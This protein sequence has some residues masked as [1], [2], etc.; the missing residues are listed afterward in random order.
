MFVDVSFNMS[1]YTQRKYAQ[2]VTNLIGGIIKTPAPFISN[3]RCQ[4]C[5][6]SKTNRLKKRGYLIERGTSIGYTCHNCGVSLSLPTFLKQYHSELFRQYWL[7]I[8]VERKQENIVE[9]Q[10]QILSIKKPISINYLL[11][12]QLIKLPFTHNA[13]QYVL[14]RKIPHN[15]LPEFYWTDQFY[16]LVNHYV[17]NKFSKWL[18]DNYEHR[19]LIMPITDVDGNWT[20]LIGRYIGDQSDIKRYLTIKF[21]PDAIK[22][23]G[24]CNLDITKQGYILEGAIDS[25]YFDNAIAMAGSDCN[26]DDIFKDGLSPIIILDNQPRNAE[27]ISRYSKYISKGYSIVVWP[28]DIIQKDV[29]EM[30]LS[31][32]GIEQIKEIIRR[33]T[34]SGLAAT[35]KLSKWKMI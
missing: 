21:Q 32:Y 2:I 19:R 5:G 9:T 1:I 18:L 15:K 24:L 26:P 23:Y 30:V 13:V 10:P 34:Y 6:D 14:S 35:I 4:I 33:N 12:M 20:G 28:S 3:F 17:P 7:D 25:M 29:N 8:I 11:I 27:V 22:A 16:K 31:G